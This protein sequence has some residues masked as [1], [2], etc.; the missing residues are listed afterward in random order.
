MGSPGKGTDRPNHRPLSTSTYHPPVSDKQEQ[1]LAASRERIDAI[2]AQIL[3]LMGERLE[4]ASAIAAVKQAM[5]EPAYYRPEREAQVLQ[6]LRE[7]KPVAMSD[8]SV[9]SLF[10]E[11]MSITRGSEARQST[12][13][14]GPAGT[15]SEVAARRHFG[16]AMEIVHEPTIE[17][18]F[19]S[20]EAGRCDFAVVPVENSTEG[21][22]N[23][24]MDR[25]VTTTLKIC[26]E[27]YLPIHHNLV[28]V[29][30][31]LPGVKRVCAH[32]QALAQCRQWL[33]EHLGDVVLIPCNSNSEGVRQAAESADAAAIAGVEAAGHYA[34]NVLAERIE[35]EPGNTTR[36][37][38]LS[39]R[40]TPPSGDDK[41]SI[42]MSAR[43]R[44][45]ALFHLLQPL[46]DHGVDMTRIESRPSRTGLWEYLFFVDML[47]HREDADVRDALEKIAAEAG[48]FRHLGSYPAA[49][50]K[51]EP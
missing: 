22:V 6:R 42:L 24:T 3:A 26:A 9:E 45:G 27:I 41:T 50:V 11:I 16:S 1:Q 20:V 12:V 19:R 8:A 2:D 7:L 38:V 15:Y 10:R 25:M 43:N 18:I 48:M 44:P 30:R 46:V 37:L 32:P 23:A 4:A 51:L 28:A 34:L 14:L 17:D 49:R 47:G 39:D 35:D 21:G 36:F 13:L 33:R 29:T 40:D 31:D 5:S